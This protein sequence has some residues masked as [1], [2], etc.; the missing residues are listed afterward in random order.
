MKYA[1][2]QCRIQTMPGIPCHF[3]ETNFF[4]F[5]KI[6]QEALKIKLDIMGGGGKTWSQDTPGSDFRF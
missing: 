5:A 1:L 6:V 4:S 2:S 3:L